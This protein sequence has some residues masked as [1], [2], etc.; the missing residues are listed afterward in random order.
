MH[1]DV[2]LVQEAIY[3]VILSKAHCCVLFCKQRF[4]LWLL[5]TVLE[6]YN[7]KNDSAALLR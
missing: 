3:Q 7:S 6:N 2:K 5:C 1:F 4:Y